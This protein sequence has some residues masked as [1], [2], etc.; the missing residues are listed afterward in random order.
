MTG[1]ISEGTGLT[2]YIDGLTIYSYAGTYGYELSVGTHVISITADAQYSIE[3]AVITFNGQTIENNG[4]IT[5]TSDMNSFTLAASGATPA[6]TTVVI[7]GGNGGS[8]M[9]LTDY[10]LI[11][12]VILIVIMAIIVALRL[13]RS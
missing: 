4:T 12:L 8:D 1:Q 5:I 10:L 13:M 3:N 11:V 7:D 9:G 6:D 2:I